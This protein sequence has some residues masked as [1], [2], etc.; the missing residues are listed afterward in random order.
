MIR[1]MAF[2]SCYNFLTL[3]LKGP[4]IDSVCLKV[5]C[6]CL[7]FSLMSQGGN[8]IHPTL[9]MLEWDGYDVLEQYGSD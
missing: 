1:M 2:S 4:F 5:S 6:D 8:P 9:S 3:L 7:S